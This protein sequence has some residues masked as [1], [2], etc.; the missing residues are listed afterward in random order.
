MRRVADSYVRWIARLCGCGVAATALVWS[1]PGCKRKRAPRR[2]PASRH[3]Q[4]GPK[5]V[6]EY[7]KGSIFELTEVAATNPQPISAFG[8]I[9]GLAGTGDTRVSNVVREHM[10]KQMERHGF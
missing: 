4:L 6:P 10:I 9:G 1:V 8:L 5:Q 7:L 3:S 2:P